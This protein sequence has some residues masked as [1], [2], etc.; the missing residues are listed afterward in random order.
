MSA[1]SVGNQTAGGFSSTLYKFE[2]HGINA[3]TEASRRRAVFKHVAEV[4][5]ASSAKH[6]CS[7]HPVTR[8]GF[9]L[10]VLGIHRI[11]EAR[12][13]RAG[14]EFLL[15][16]KQLS[17]ATNAAEYS[18]FV[19]VPKLAG[20]RAL[21]APVTRHLVLLRG[22]DLLPLRVRFDH[23]FDAH[24]APLRHGH[25]RVRDVIPRDAKL[26]KELRIYR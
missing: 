17:S 10:N 6:F 13:T 12:P 21:G 25:A 3:I 11:R 2:G 4:R 9:E 15:G 23:F 26:V 8:I 22:K 7:S 20:E 18:V 16:M 14:L 19:E 24:S 1:A 5:V